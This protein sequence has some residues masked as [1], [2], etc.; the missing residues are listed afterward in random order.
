MKNTHQRNNSSDVDALLVPLKFPAFF[1]VL[2][3]TTV[4]DDVAGSRILW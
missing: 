1:V 3:S 4:N 2:D